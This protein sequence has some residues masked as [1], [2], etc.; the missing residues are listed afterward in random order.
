MCFTILIVQALIK[1]FLFKNQIQVRTEPTP[2]PRP[3]QRM[4]SNNTWKLDC[5]AAK[6][7]VPLGLSE[8]PNLVDGPPHMSPLA[9]TRG[10]RCCPG[11]PVSVVVITAGD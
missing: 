4:A 5:T 1:L 10:S 6:E 11:C 8:R 3:L 2:A 9:L 7:K